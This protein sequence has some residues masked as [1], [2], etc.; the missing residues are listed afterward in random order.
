MPNT[1]PVFSVYVTGL[2][3]KRNKELGGTRYYEEVNRRKKDKVY[4]VVREGEAKGVLKGH[5]KEGS[6]SWMNVVFV[7]LGEGAEARFLKGAEERGMNGLKGHRSVGGIRV[8]LYN[9]IT[10][11]QVDKLVAYIREFIQQEPGVPPTLPSETL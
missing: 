9:A 1:P 3:L 8:S 7:V 4:G 11:E 10:E 2:V 5:V 6:G